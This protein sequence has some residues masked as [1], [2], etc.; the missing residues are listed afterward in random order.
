MPSVISGYLTFYLKTYLPHSTALMIGDDYLGT[1]P[2]RY[3][4]GVDALIVGHIISHDGL[5]DW[6]SF[7]NENPEAQA[8]LT[9]LNQGID[10]VEF[11][12]ENLQTWCCEVKRE[13]KH[14]EAV[15][16]FSQ[17]NQML[18]DGKTDEALLLTEQK[19]TVI[20]TDVQESDVPTLDDVADETLELVEGYEAG[21]DKLH[22]RTCF[23][24][25]TSYYGGFAAGALNALIGIGGSGKT[26][27]LA[28]DSFICAEKTGQVSVWFQ[29]EMARSEMGL[30]EAIR[31]SGLTLDEMQKH[32]WAASQIK[33]VESE[34]KQA[35]NKGDIEEH[36]KL[37]VRYDELAKDLV[38]TF[39]ALKDKIKSFRGFPGQVSIYTDVG[40]NA[41]QILQKLRKAKRKF[42]RIDKVVIDNMRLC[43]L[44]DPRT[45]PK[46]NGNWFKFMGEELKIH[47]V[48]EF[49]ETAFIA[50]QHMNTELERSKA[51]G[52]DDNVKLVPQMADIEGNTGNLY[53]Q[54][55]VIMRPI[56]HQRQLK[57]IFGEFDTLPEAQQKEWREKC[58]ITP[59]KN[60]MGN[61]NRQVECRYVGELYNF[62]GS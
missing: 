31:R 20:L 41:L 57:T 4:E 11:S 47:V 53:H 32:S 1:D 17:A 3:F 48:R 40:L 52:S 55:F 23:H 16:L 29:M 24:K 49:P 5:G 58:I 54:A 62:E 37:R 43:N 33:R 59:V 60:R 44:I 39:P 35:I 13:K 51:S 18:K 46:S 9:A 56:Q 25:F 42:G 7:R 15:L 22:V 14:R 45:A 8:R 26:T 27:W 30:K 38:N 50:I 34:M 2:A 21:D 12:H 6:A 28:Q 19:S 10:A 36:H 61:P